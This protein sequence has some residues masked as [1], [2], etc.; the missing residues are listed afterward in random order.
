[1]RSIATTPVEVDSARQVQAEQHRE[2]VVMARRGSSPGSTVGGVVILLFLGWL[3]VQC[4]GS[5]GQ[6]TAPS[7]DAMRPPTSSRYVEATPASQGSP[8]SRFVTASTL[9]LRA[10]PHGEVIDQLSAGDEVRLEETQRDWIRVI[11]NGKRGWVASRHTCQ[12]TR[13]WSRR[14]PARH[15]PVARRH[16]FGGSCPCSGSFNCTGPRGGQYCITSG[17]NK[18]YR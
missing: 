8:E 14:A 11:A 4:A 13:C 6:R 17:G 15:A 2:R 3:L 18:R 5:G 9:N 7:R 16:S 10:S 12:G 1:M